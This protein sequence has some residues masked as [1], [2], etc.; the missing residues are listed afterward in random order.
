MTNWKV[1]W[2]L[3]FF[4]MLYYNLFIWCYSFAVENKF[5]RFR[6]CKEKN[7]EGR[8]IFFSHYNCDQL[9]AYQ[10][11]FA[12]VSHFFSGIRLPVDGEDLQMEVFQNELVHF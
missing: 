11:T 12:A 5:I 9:K 1:Y 7:N 10:D 6:V 2:S 4:P 3:L 8:Y